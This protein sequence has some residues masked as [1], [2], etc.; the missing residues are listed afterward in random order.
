MWASAITAYFHYLSLGVIF[1]TLITEFFTLKEE[2]TLKDAWRILW[3]DTAYGIA[4]L[5]VLGTGILRVLY[6][7]KET[8]YYMN[9]PVFWMKMAV[10]LVVG[11]LSLYPTISFLG[12]IKSLTQEKPPEITFN[13]YK[14]LKYIIIVELCGFT[15]IP[16]LA[17]M[18][19]RGIGT[20]WFSS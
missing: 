18:M 5:T 9:Q 17:S 12:W 7:G 3:A 2:L 8:A 1:A 19:A 4:A 11:T 10:F 6:Y 16:L 14:R 20:Q 13:K 15:L